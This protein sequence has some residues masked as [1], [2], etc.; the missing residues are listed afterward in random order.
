MSHDSLEAA[1]TVDATAV[2]VDP[3]VAES[4]R[5]ERNVTPGWMWW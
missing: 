3:A 1:V 5:L 4:L 2:V